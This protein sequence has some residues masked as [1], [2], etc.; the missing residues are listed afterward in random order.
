[1]S[2]L[3]GVLRL[4]KDGKYSVTWTTDIDLVTKVG[5]R[6]LRF[7]ALCLCC[8]LVTHLFALPPCLL[9]QH[10]EAGRGMELSELTL[11]NGQCTTPCANKA[12]CA[13]AVVITKRAP[14]ACCHVTGVMY[15]FDDRSG[16]VFEVD[17]Y[18]TNTPKT[19]PR[20]ILTEGALQRL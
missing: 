5:V 12:V 10:A 19:Y 17:G 11:F 13:N 20:Y 7:A 14:W 3:Q 8:H 2:L 16:I 9:Q 4:N 18:D 15:T 6:R 1:M